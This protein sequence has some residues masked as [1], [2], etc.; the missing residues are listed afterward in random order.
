[1]FSGGKMILA[2]RASIDDAFMSVALQVYAQILRKKQNELSR[3]SGFYGAQA[4][5]QPVISRLIP[6]VKNVNNGRTG[7]DFEKTRLRI[8]PYTNF[9][10]LEYGGTTW[11]TGKTVPVIIKENGV[12]YQ[13]GPY[14]VCVPLSTFENGNLNGIHFIPMKM[15]LSYNRHP[16]HHAEYPS[17]GTRAISHPLANYPRTCWGNYG[18]ILSAII[19]DGDI[20]EMFRQF[21]I[22]LTRYNAASPLIHDMGGDY[23]KRGIE[24][25]DFDTSK[26]W[27]EK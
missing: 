19:N 26:P 6:I 15:P 7:L 24:C 13:M 12:D 22:Y 17:T 21:Y 25:I 11:L 5:I 20:P 14:K 8:L 18:A 3:N 16:H 1:M 27:E 10:A 23:R 4:N 9:S 2:K